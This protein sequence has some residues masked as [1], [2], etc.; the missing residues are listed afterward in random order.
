MVQEIVESGYAADNEV[1]T[2]P[3]TVGRN[4]IP[5]KNLNIFKPY[6]GWSSGPTA[7]W[8]A[9]THKH[10]EIYIL[11][12]DYKGL[13]GKLNNMYADTQN[14][15]KS[16]DSATYYGNWSKQTIKCIKEFRHIQYYRVIKEDNY[17]PLQLAELPNVKHITYS[18]FIS[19]S[20]RI[21]QT[22]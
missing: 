6:K 20:P 21:I 10:A 16:T 5:R 4:T 19:K 13:N 3:I 14:Y 7:L 12:F 1:W 2:N 15:K 9:S 22:S 11:G 18:E 17:I 8:M